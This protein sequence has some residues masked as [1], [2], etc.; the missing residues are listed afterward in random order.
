MLRITCKVKVTALH[1]WLKS[2]SH[3][4]WR[5]ITEAACTSLF[6]ILI[7]SSRG[8]FEG[9][10]NLRKI[11]TD[12]THPQKICQSSMP[13]MSKLL[14]CSWFSLSFL[15]FKM[16]SSCS[17]NW[18]CFTLQKETPR[19]ARV[20]QRE[21]KKTLESGCFSIAVQ[22]IKKINKYY[23]LKIQYVLYSQW[24]HMHSCDQ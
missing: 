2:I 20:A 14:G 11:E 15:N 1:Q 13:E 17:L 21:F 3:T 24:V 6:L 23:I 4:G 7:F 8:V 5:S 10:G 12:I 9:K 19:G 16:R 22:I 18:R